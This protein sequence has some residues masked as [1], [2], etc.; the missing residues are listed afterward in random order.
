MPEGDWAV[1]MVAS[2][3]R[4]KYS[5]YSTIQE[6]LC[7]VDKENNLFMASIKM[8]SKIIISK[9]KNSVSPNRTETFAE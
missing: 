2:L 9:S 5:Y 7:Q 1:V 4:Q 6:L 8:H 3:T